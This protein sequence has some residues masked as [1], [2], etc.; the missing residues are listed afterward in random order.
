MEKIFVTDKNFMVC[1]VFT[2]LNIAI[3]SNEN[4]QFSSKKYYCEKCDY[5]TDRKSNFYNH[6]L[7][8]KH[9]KS[10]NSNENKQKTSTYLCLFARKSRL[11]IA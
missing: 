3:F 8:A 7:T 5:T 1:L 9:I 11:K 2:L 10:M 4:K 6:N